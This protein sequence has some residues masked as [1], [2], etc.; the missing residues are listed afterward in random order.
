MPA[1]SAVLNV[2][3][4]AKPLRDETVIQ[5]VRESSSSPMEATLLD[6]MAE[7]H[8]SMVDSTAS[9]IP[10]INT[11]F[12]DNPSC[13]DF[14]NDNLTTAQRGTHTHPLLEFG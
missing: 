7:A 6:K 4:T 11:Q 14:S 12:T 3:I 1:R 10:T 9:D 2:S 5:Q 8:R 13:L